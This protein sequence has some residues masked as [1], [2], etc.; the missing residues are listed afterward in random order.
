[1]LTHSSVECEK[2]CLWKYITNKTKIKGNLIEMKASRAVTHIY[3]SFDFLS[4]SFIWPSRRTMHLLVQNSL[5]KTKSWVSFTG[6]T[7][8]I[9]IR[10]K[11]SYNKFISTDR[12]CVRRAGRKYLKDISPVDSGSTFIIRKS[13]NR[14]I[15][16]V[17]MDP[18]GSPRPT[19]GSTQHHSE[20][21][22][23]VWEP[24]C[25]LNSFFSTQPTSWWRTFSWYWTWTSHDW[26]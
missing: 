24:R 13:Q 18:E 5:F 16:R 10:P 14:G 8:A 12:Q 25:F 9:W 1:M 19:P 2:R 20:I 7:L 4:F 21:R 17:G 23:Y 11:Y 22:L 6:Y 26:S 3:V 15:S